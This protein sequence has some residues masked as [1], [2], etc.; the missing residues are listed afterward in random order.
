MEEDVQE[1]A[2]VVRREGV[3]RSLGKRRLA[4]WSHGSKVG[5]VENNGVS[6][7]RGQSGGMVAGPQAGWA[8]RR[9]VLRGNI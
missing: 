8:G 6:G 1:E 4:R 2:M 7:A 5:E 9:G 3:G